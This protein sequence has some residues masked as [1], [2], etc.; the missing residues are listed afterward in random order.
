[1]FFVFR[2]MLVIPVWGAMRL[3]DNVVITL[4]LLR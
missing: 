1:M 3:H 4:A 2:V